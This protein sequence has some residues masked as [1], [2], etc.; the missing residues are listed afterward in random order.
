MIVRSIT[1]NNSGISGESENDDRF[2]LNTEQYNAV[3]NKSSLLVI[4]GD[5]GT[6]KTLVLKERAKMYANENKDE[7]IAFINLTG[8]MIDKKISSDQYTCL[9]IMDY[10]AVI[11]FDKYH[12]VQVIS[13]CKLNSVLFS[14]EGNCSIE[15]IIIRAL[16]TFFVKNS[17]LHIFIDEMITVGELL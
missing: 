7:K 1:G 6:G 11:D 2:M 14:H 13:C 9:T 15:E 5:Y 3:H 10:I 16:E 12:N 17:Y 4:E 8:L